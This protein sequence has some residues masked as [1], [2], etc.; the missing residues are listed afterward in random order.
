MEENA[1]EFARRRIPAGKSGEWRL[2]IGENLAQ[3]FVGAPTEEKAKVTAAIDDRRG[4]RAKEREIARR[5][6]ESG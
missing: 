1:T 3:S 5:E 6:G 4:K 2:R